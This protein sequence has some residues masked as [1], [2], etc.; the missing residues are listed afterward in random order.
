MSIKVAVRVRP[1]NDREKQ[2]NSTCCVKMVSGVSISIICLGW[3]NNRDYWSYG[4]SKALYIRLQFLVAWWLWIGWRRH[5]QSSGRKY[6][7]WL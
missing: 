4:K 3:S 5:L 7:C 2:G 6:I 1:Y